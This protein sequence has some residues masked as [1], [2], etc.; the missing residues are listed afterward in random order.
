M[1][2]RT[3]PRT[4]VGL[5][6]TE[7]WITLVRWIDAAQS[8]RLFAVKGLDELGRRGVAAHVTLALAAR[9]GHTPGADLGASAFLGAALAA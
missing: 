4:R 6:A 1:R 9:G 5:A 8:G 7:R 3:S 2:T